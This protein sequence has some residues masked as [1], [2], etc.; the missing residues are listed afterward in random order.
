[1]REDLW[2]E[3]FSTDYP[4]FQMFEENFVANVIKNDNY[5]FWCIKTTRGLIDYNVENWEIQHMNIEIKGKEK[6]KIQ[7]DKTADKKEV[8]KKEVGKKTSLISMLK[9]S[10]KEK[11]EEKRKDFSS[12][13]F[14]K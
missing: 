3:Y 4:K 14:R 7:G 5:P 10:N 9:G 1:L 8:E 12:L 11:P 6:T 13:F 2:E